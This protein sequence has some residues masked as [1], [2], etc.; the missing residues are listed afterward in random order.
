M[1]SYQCNS[2]QN[3]FKISKLCLKN[4]DAEGVECIVPYD[5][6]VLVFRYIEGYFLII[7]AIIFGI[8]NLL[9][10]LSVL[11][12]KKR[13]RHGFDSKFRQVTIFILHLCVVDVLWSLTLTMPL[14]YE[15]IAMKWPFGEIVCRLKVMLVIMISIVEVQSIAL[16]SIS[17]YLD[18]TKNNLWRNWT[19]NKLGLPAIL[20][21]PWLL[22]S[23]IL[24]L[25]WIPSMEVDFTWN[26]SA[27]GCGVISDC[28]RSNCNES[29]S[30]G[31]VF[32]TGYI[33]FLNFF[34][35]IVSGMLYFLLT[36]VVKSTSKYLKENAAKCGKSLANIASKIDERESKMTRT[37]LILIGV[38]IVCNIPMVLIQVLPNGEQSY[39]IGRQKD[40]AMILWHV[41]MIIWIF[42]FCVNFFIYAGSNEQ[43]QMAYSDL[44]NT[45]KQK[46]LYSLKQK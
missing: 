5:Y 29:V 23:I 18:L 31:V 11:L 30:T 4:Q 38:H 46:V 16:V 20:L 19:N 40:G 7:A 24:F 37:I 17:R 2:T 39:S 34:S 13:Q 26:C 12:A 3:V 35:V 43:Y 10:L 33:L 32:I 36:S 41:V 42:Q 44:K 9:T 28:T 15:L 45:L 1:N 21:T 14:S 6:S 25:P 8:G 22:S 27:G